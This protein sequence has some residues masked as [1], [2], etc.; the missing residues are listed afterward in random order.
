MRL[1]KCLCQTEPRKRLGWHSA[2]TAGRRG[3]PASFE[4]A[5]RVAILANEP[6][7]Q[8]VN[9]SALLDRG[10][11]LVF[12]PSAREVHLRTAG[13]FWDQEVFN[14][15]GRSLQLAEQ[16]SMRDYVLGWELK[17]AGM[18]WKG[19]LLIR[20]ASVSDSDTTVRGF[21]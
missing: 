1:L 13:W 20:S 5:S 14:F 6:P 11:V 7:T 18:D 4:T 17:R 9:V 2:A 16:L 19:W 10:H 21:P 3:I 8:S 12:D 15:I